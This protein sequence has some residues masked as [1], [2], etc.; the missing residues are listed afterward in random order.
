MT[1]RELQEIEV[2]ASYEDVSH[3]DVTKLLTEIRR[4]HQLRF[5]AI[6]ESDVFKVLYEKFSEMI[7]QIE[8]KSMREGASQMRDAAARMV[9]E[10]VEHG[11]HIAKE[12]KRLPLP[13]DEFANL[14]FPV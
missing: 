12:I 10:E 4:L 5:T 7:P 13:G 1:E 11:E 8:L 2:K 6:K 3:N 9:T 14:Q